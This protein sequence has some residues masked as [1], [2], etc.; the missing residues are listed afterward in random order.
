MTKSSP[1][2]VVD[3]KPTTSQAIPTTEMVQQFQSLGT[4]IVILV[5]LIY[6]IRSL[7]DLVKACKS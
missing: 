4:A 2:Q 6:F 7:T 1:I 5:L 3:S